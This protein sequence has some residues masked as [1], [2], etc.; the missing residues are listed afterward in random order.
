MNGLRIIAIIGPTAIGKTALSLKM[1]MGYSCEIVS[2]DSMQVYRYM[3]VG[4][5]KASEEERRQVP[6]H[7]ID[8]V[9]PDDEYN[10]SRY[11]DDAGKA[12]RQIAARG[13]IPLLVG[14]SGLY[15]RG[16]LEGLSDVVSIDAKIREA[17]RLDIVANG[18]EWLFAEVQRVDPLAA[19]RVHPHDTQRLIR[20]L[21]VYRSSGKTWTEHL[22]T[23]RQRPLDAQVLL[24]G[25]TCDRNDLYDRINRRVTS[26]I[27][28]G[29]LEE[30]R[31]LLAKGYS[32][33]LKS[34][35]SIGYRHM[36]NYIDRVWSWDEAV[37]FL[38]RDTRRYAKRQYTWFGRDPEINWLDMNEGG[39][40]VAMKMAGRFLECA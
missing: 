9:D 8:I 5:A 11:V 24:L 12:C 10:V 19:L 14:G 38:A 3:D 16:L 15:L 31:G 21:E 37:R 4:T 7:L 39:A 30:T 13:R 1:S 34:M 26:M 6:H 20:A 35:Q 40:D 32:G 22:S 29:L 23:G 18:K 33:A 25:L 2:V 17:I 36:V 27:E 28:G